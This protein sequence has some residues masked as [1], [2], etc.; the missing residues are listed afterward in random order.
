MNIIK[1]EKLSNGNYKLTI[2]TSPTEK[3]ISVDDAGYYRLGGQ[4]GDVVQGHCIHEAQRVMW[5]SATQKW[6]EV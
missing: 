3:V 5:E 6:E 1:K 2:I 4:I